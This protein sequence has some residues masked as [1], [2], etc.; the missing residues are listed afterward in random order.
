MKSCISSLTVFKRRLYVDDIQYHLP[1]MLRLVVM[2][3]MQQDFVMFGDL[4][5]AVGALVK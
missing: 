4:E 5:I 1:C 2:K 3:N